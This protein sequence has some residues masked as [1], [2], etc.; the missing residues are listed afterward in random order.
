MFSTPIFLVYLFIN[1]LTQCDSRHLNKHLD[2]DAVQREVRSYSDVANQII[3]FSL[4]GNGKGQSYN[5][6]ANFTDKFGNRIAGSQNLEN[7]ID[8]MLVEM[9]KDKLENVHGEV[10]QVPHWVR[11]DESA[12]LLLP[13][14]KNLPMLGLGSSIATPPDGIEADVLVVK[15]FDELNEKASEAK[16]KIVVFN[17]DW[18]S[19]GVSVAYRSLGASRAAQNG[20]VASL[21][22]SVT[23]LSISSPH[24]GWQDYQSGVPKIPTACITVEDAEMMWRMSQR[25]EKIR[26]RL[27]ME[28]QLLPSVNSRNTVAEIKGSK[29]P[30]EVV[31]VSGHLDSWD[32]GQGAMDDGGGAFISWQALS[33]IRQ[34]NLR[35]KRTM[36]AVLWT[37]EEEGLVGSREYYEAHK[38]EADKFD[39]VLESDEG[40]FTPDGLTF[41]GSKQAGQIM[42]QVLELLKP[43]NASKLSESGAGG[44]IGYFMDVGVPGGNLLNE[45]QHYFYFHHTNGD[46]MTVQDPHVMDMCSAVWAVIAYTVADL[47]EMLPRNSTT[48]KFVP[49]G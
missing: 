10:A 34:L 23:P 25:G 12:V 5:R 17:Q 29:Y 11:G 2:I 15:T 37:A 28:A 21:I 30:D 7:A 1:L 26:I 41:G 39:L 31:L 32:V 36:R 19:Y 24:T 16:G 13:R 46:T 47:E 49:V 33:I 4:N 22:R 42:K 44:D 18:V 27:K 8:Y 38:S 35:P 3:D 6:L 48:L 45:N 14:K 9:S 40:V 43:I 20:A